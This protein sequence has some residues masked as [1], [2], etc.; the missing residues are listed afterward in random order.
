M[1]GFWCHPG[2]GQGVE[3]DEHA[4]ILAE[5]AGNGQASPPGQDVHGKNKG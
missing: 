5:P 2:A 4:C 1:I 3:V